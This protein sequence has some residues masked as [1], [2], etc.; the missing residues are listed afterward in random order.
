MG[1]QGG[2]A[3]RGARL[4]LPPVRWYLANHQN[5]KHVAASEN[6]EFPIRA[7]DSAVHPIDPRRF[8]CREGI[9]VGPSHH[10]R[11]WR[12]LLQ[13]GYQFCDRHYAAPG[14]FLPSDSSHH[15][16]LPPVR[17]VFVFLT[18][19]MIL[20]IASAAETSITTFFIS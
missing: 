3:I 17:C 6:I 1:R 8:H 5:R 19:S 2:K 4:T 11:F 20:A 10:R 13:L 12:M 14:L 18:P 7:A 15:T 16:P 9:K